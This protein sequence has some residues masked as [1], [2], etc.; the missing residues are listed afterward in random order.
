M[1]F[2]CA[3]VMLA[4]HLGVLLAPRL[5]SAPVCDALAS[6]SL[7]LCLCLARS[8]R[9]RRTWFVLLLGCLAVLHVA[10]QA[11][12]RLAQRL[13]GHLL[14]AE[15]VVQGVIASLP[16]AQG[17]NLSFILEDAVA[18][19]T[20]GARL[21]R[22]I[23]VGWYR[24]ARL[25]A[26]GSL[27][28]IRLRLRPAR[29]LL[30]PGGF[31]TDGWFFR[32]GIGAMASVVSN[33]ARPLP[34]RST[35]R[36]L[37]RLRGVI[38]G[39]IG[40]ALDGHPMQGMVTGLAVGVRQ[41]ISAAQWR[42]LSLTGTGH[43]VA[44]SGLHIGLVAGLAYLLA[45]LAWGSSLW[46]STRMAPVDAA[47]PV[48]LFAALTYALLAGFALPTR[49]ALIMLMLWYGARA[50]RRPLGGA[51]TFSIALLI[52]LVMD[53]LCVLSPGFW[54]SFMAV[55]ALIL[56]SA[57]PVSGRGRTLI[58]AQL[59]IFAGLAPVGLAAFGHVSVIAPLANLLLV[60]FF[61]LL[62]IPLV[63]VGVVFTLLWPWLG[64]QLLTGCAA[65]LSLAWQALTLLGT[66]PA[67]SPGQAGRWLLVAAAALAGAM[68]LLPPW[69]GK[70]VL[71]VA[72]V[73]AVILSRPARPAEG[74]VAVTVLD[75]GHAL[76]VVVR[77]RRH[78][79]VYDLGAGKGD[80]SSVQ[81]VILPFLR[82]SGSG[83]PD[84]LMLSHND[85]HH[86]GD[87]QAFV[88][89]Y[90]GLAVLS[91]APRATRGQL[92]ADRARPCRRDQ[93]WRWDQ[94][95]FHILQPG[96]EIV[97]EDDDSSCILLIQS[98]TMSVL[99][100][101]DLGG[102][103]EARLVQRHPEL[104]A[105]IVIGL[106]HG[107]ARSSSSTLASMLRPRLVVFSTRMNN[108]W[109]LPK[110]LVAQRWRKYGAVVLDTGQ[111]GAVSILPNDPWE[112]RY[113]RSGNLW[114]R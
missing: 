55:G 104:R 100:T 112:H 2:I 88:E 74:A 99:I 57:R 31:D 90:P 97:W 111:Y 114:H 110:A 109:G 43:L 63:L 54:L 84:I 16:D 86:L 108:A 13:P 92:G 66:V 27:W 73:L 36:P 81:R 85:P 79:L 69:R 18:V 25:P 60:P 80:A 45:R 34:G 62:L 68:V 59:G 78:T 87:A 7:V 22:K 107:S 21:P 89:E 1:L 64:G 77:T 102:S 40:R 38:A 17:D 94:V 9:L 3:A 65:L 26:V 47:W 41:D 71:L 56:V 20:P 50:L 96:P 103:G 53:P 70:G 28:E 46:L 24:S 91:G 67:F 95:E 52:I 19:A 14:G 32:E 105:D 76:S 4:A 72:L 113:E 12:A 82:F 75:V 93:R 58:A 106:A 39:K 11:G 6:L 33:H 35:L 37:L 15:I 30:N 8:D 48:A 51:R 101:G 42:L 49:R 98:Q 5:P 23:R 61:G 29:G 44:I 83:R 10:G